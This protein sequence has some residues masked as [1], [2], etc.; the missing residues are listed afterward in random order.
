MLCWWVAGS[1][2][3]ARPQCQAGR[4]A[5]FLAKQGKVCQLE[6]RGPLFVPLGQSVCHPTLA[7]GV[8]ALVVLDALYR[9]V[10]EGS[11]RGGEDSDEWAMTKEP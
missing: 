6:E 5:S 2:E 3:K 4:S 1:P 7:F 11:L 8:D 10:C 9:R